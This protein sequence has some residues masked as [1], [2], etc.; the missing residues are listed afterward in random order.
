M[1]GSSSSRGKANVVEDVVV[2]LD[3]RETGLG[4]ERSVRRDEGSS[5]QEPVKE[6]G[7]V[8]GTDMCDLLLSLDTSPDTS[9]S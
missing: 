5:A 8:Y 6:D 7:D 3:G 2:A 1:T 9:N 4:G